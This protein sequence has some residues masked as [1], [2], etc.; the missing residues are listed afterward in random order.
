MTSFL[1]WNCRGFKNKQHKIQELISDHGPICFAFQEIYLKTNDTVT[2]RGY[3]CF[4]KDVH[5]ASRA[6]GGIAM[7]V[8]NNFP[9]STISL[10]SKATYTSNA[11]SHLKWLREI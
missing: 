1:S 10:N 5:H 7:L 9:H 3:S 4:K 6:T 8:S 11:F 2:I